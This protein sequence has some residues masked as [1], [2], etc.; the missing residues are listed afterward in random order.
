[1]LGQISTLYR[2]IHPAVERANGDLDARE[3][4]VFG[5]FLA[6]RDVRS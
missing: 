6:A 5:Y 2:L 1:M 3:C 4:R